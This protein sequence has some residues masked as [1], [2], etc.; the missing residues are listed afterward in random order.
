ML[1]AATCC[2]CCH[3]AGEKSCQ[4]VGTNVR[5]QVAQWDLNCY[6]LEVKVPRDLEPSA[7]WLGPYW[8]QFTREEGGSSGKWQTGRAVHCH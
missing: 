2:V 6:P 7:P 1:L 3:G 4:I 8:E 5:G